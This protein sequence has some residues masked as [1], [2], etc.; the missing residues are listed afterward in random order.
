MKNSIIQKSYIDKENKDYIYN[1]LKD[2]EKRENIKILHAI[3]SGSRAWG[4][5]SKNSDYDVRFIY[6]RTQQ[7]YLSIEQPIDNIQTPIV[8][9]QV[10]A[11]PYDLAGWDLR[12]ALHLILKSNAIVHEWLS[13]PINYIS[14]ATFLKEVKDFYLKTS[15]LDSVTYHYFS[16]ANGIWNALLKEGKTLT[17]KKYLYVIRPVLCL[18]YIYQNKTFPP[19][20]LYLLCNGIDVED[21]IIMSLKKLVDMKEK[22]N[23]SDLVERYAVLDEFISAILAVN[24]DRNKTFSYSPENL[25]GA[26]DIFINY[27]L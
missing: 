21:E 18:C 8:D 9:D 24:I 12:K 11:A 27:F 20:D 23:E 4:F 5:P 22:S 3:E 6:S 1:K 25:Q 2:F 15:S 10:L 26:N 7:Q 13:S 17:V 14:N 16:I 19:M